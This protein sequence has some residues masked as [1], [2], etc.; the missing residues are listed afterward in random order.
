M[1]KY[2]KCKY[3]P[4]NSYRIFS[5]LVTLMILSVISMISITQT[6]AAYVDIEEYQQEQ[7]FAD[8]SIG[9]YDDRTALDSE[10]YEIWDEPST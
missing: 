6:N 2:I 8:D 1:A 3:R 5:Y 10:L 7:G 4:I 9:G